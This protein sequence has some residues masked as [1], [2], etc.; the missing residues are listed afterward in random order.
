MRYSG[1]LQDKVSSTDLAALLALLLALKGR[2]KERD[3]KFQMVKD[4]SIVNGLW[5]EIKCAYN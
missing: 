4:N 3:Q 5:G 1:F 2:Q